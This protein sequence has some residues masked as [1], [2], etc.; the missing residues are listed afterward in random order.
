ML[1]NES[2]FESSS[3]S[4]MCKFIKQQ[5]IESCTL[6]IR[7]KEKF[8]IVGDTVFFGVQF[9]QVA[10]SGQVMRTVN[11]LSHLTMLGRQCLHVRSV[12]CCE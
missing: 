4:S 3:S 7:N 1:D 9:C 5:C 6:K 10:H 12:T 8:D 11:Q 2:R